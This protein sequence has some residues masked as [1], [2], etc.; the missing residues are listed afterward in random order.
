VSRP[1]PGKKQKVATAGAKR[2]RA[3]LSP[4]SRDAIVSAAIALAD[5]EGLDAVSLRNVASALDAGPMRL[6]GHVDS[7]EA[8]LELMVDSV[9][10]ELEAPAPGDWREA[11]RSIARGLRK[12]ADEHPW[13]IGL[14]GARPNLGEN[15][16]SYMEACLASLNFADIDYTLES[17]RIVKAYAIGAIQTEATEIASGQNRDQWQKESWPFVQKMLASGRYPMM[18]RVVRE[19][20][21]PPGEFERGLE[22]VL[23]GIEAGLPKRR[24]PKTP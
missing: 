16:F 10:A 21:H 12:A 7:K 1:A 4:L 5:R 3:E 23:V 13:F 22:R 14:L 20:S 11:M 9:Y 8:L 17:L 6:Y 2:A 19:A 15:S 18:D 24:R